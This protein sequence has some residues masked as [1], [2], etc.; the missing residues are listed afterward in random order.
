MERTERRSERNFEIELKQ[1]KETSSF[2]TPLEVEGSSSSHGDPSI[3]KEICM[4]GLTNFGS[5]QYYFYNNKP[6]QSFPILS[7]A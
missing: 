6:K 4:M 3:R 1:S 7:P 5:K 2:D